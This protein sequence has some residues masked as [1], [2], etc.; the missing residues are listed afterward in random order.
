MAKVKAVKNKNFA[1]GFNQYTE[2]LGGLSGDKRFLDPIIVLDK[3]YV[4]KNSISTISSLL[5]SFNKSL[6]SNFNENESKYLN[7]FIKSL[8]IHIENKDIQ[9]DNVIDIYYEIKNSDEVAELLAI[10]KKLNVYHDELNKT[11]YKEIDSDF[12]TQNICEKITL[13][14]FGSLNIIDLY[15]K[16]DSCLN[17]LVLLLHKLYQSLK[18]I[19]K[20]MTTPDINPQ[21]IADIVVDAL[22]NLKKSVKGCDKAFNK[23][24]QSVEKIVKNMDK[25]Y[26]MLI[27]TKDPT[28]LFSGFLNDLID[29]EDDDVDIST[30]M[31]VKKIMTE[32]KRMTGNKQRRPEVDQLFDQIDSIFT[33]LENDI[34]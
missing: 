9:L 26:K 5:K 24:E 4:M 19:Y 20:A 15:L 14:S 7:D 29:N 13:F 18:D 22:G 6:V 30:I 11:N 32:F 34:E 21:K 1:N 31:Q 25:Y 27:M 10:L 33:I 23:I 12:I 28:S 8:E 16:D 3:Y 17:Y 2:I